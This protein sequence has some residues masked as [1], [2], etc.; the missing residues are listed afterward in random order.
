[1]ELN[2]GEPFEFDELLIL[3]GMLL[4]IAGEAVTGKTSVLRPTGH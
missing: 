1:M 4:C 3:F 2:E